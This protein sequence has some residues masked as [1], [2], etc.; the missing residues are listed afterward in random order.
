MPKT[1]P[2]YHTIKKAFFA[3]FLAIFVFGFFPTEVS[4]QMVRVKKNR[5]KQKRLCKDVGKIK[6][7]KAREPFWR[8]WFS[9]D[10]ENNDAPNR[11]AKTKSNEKVLLTA[12]QNNDD[13]VATTIA[14]L[15]EI[16]E[17]TDT[18]NDPTDWYRSDIPTAPVLSPIYEDITPQAQIS[19]DLK[20]AARYTRY[21]YK[22]YIS[23]YLTREEIIQ[24]N[25]TVSPSEQALQI[26]DKLILDNHAVA[27]RIE[28]KTLVVDN[29][30]EK[31]RIEIRIVAEN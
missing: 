4:A 7:K 10:E 9:H 22:V 29:P 30:Q 15:Q 31:K 25:L 13:L 26:K 5:F 14:D 27:E 23:Q 28:I 17:K 11:T 3:L 1:T 19:E 6:V 18:N 24:K 21:G 12:S 8:S 2:T 20:T 16:D